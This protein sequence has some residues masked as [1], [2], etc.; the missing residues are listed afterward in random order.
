MLGLPWVTWLRFVIWLIVGM[1]LYLAYGYKN[2]KLRDE[3]VQ[4]LSGVGS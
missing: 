1:A 3:E 2:S 4:G